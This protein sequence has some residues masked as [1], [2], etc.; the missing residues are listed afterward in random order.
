MSKKLLIFLFPFFGILYCLKKLFGP[1]N[2]KLNIIGFVRKNK[3]FS[4]ISEISMALLIYEKK[5]IFF[6][7]N[8]YPAIF[9]PNT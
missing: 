1:Q 2:K 9:G 5:F 7:K 4:T 3:L 8:A 6:N